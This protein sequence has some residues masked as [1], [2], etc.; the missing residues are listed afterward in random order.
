MPFAGVAAMLAPAANV[1]RADPPINATGR[2]RSAGGGRG[3]SDCPQT[4]AQ[5]AHRAVLAALLQKLDE[6]L[7]VIGLVEDVHAAVAAVDHMVDAVIDRGGVVW[8]WLQDSR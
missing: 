6:R 8:P 2:T 3:A 1:C 4:V 5:D 7:K